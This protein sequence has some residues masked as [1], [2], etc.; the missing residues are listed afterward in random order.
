MCR[1][2]AKFVRHNSR[3]KIGGS[4]REYVCTNFAHFSDKTWT[5]YEYQAA[6]AN[7][8]SNLVLGLGVWTTCSKVFP[9]SNSVLDKSLFAG[10]LKDVPGSHGNLHVPLSIFR[11]HHLT[12]LNLALWPITAQNLRSNYWDPPPT[13]YPLFT[14]FSGPRSRTQNSIVMRRTG[15]ARKFPGRAGESRFLTQGIPRSPKIQREIGGT[16]EH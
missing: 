7:Q 4:F 11:H 8:L 16:W 14:T 3:T 13:H 9:D 15:L 10:S 5:L 2:C 6:Q 12:N 1:D